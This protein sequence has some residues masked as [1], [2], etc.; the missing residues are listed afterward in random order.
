MA[1]VAE[2]ACIELVELVTDYLE[3]ALPAAE[4]ARFEEHLS[5]CEGCVD[6]LEQ[7]RTTIAL[8]GRLRVA[9]LSPEAWDGL[10][11]LFHGW[12]GDHPGE[13]ASG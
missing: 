8:T 11:T 10:L 2:L 13:H 5:V 4:R 3:G 7:M 1:D 12:R 9:D 6:Y